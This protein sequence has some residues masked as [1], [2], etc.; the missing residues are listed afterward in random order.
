MGVDPHQ[1]V[2]NRSEINEQLPALAASGGALNTQ[3]ML[4]VRGIHLLE[5]D[6]SEDCVWPQSEVIRSKTFPQTEE[7]FVT[8]HL[9]NDVDCAFVLGFAVDDL[10]IL[11]ARLGDIDGH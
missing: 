5:E 3:D 10:H 1:M 4:F 8:R 11:N 6:E 7:A 9:Q 2:F